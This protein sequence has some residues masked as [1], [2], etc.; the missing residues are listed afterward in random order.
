MA[1]FEFKDSNYCAFWQD[2]EVLGTYVDMT[3][4]LRTNFNF[5]ES[6]FKIDPSLTPSDSK[7]LAAFT[8]Q[9]LVREPAPMMDMV[10]PLG[11]G[12]ALDKPGLSAYTASIPHFRA[13]SYHENSQERAYMA[14]QFEQFGKDAELIK[15]WTFTIQGMLDSANQT[16]SNMS[17]QLLSTGEIDYKYGR[18]IK[19]HLYNANIPA[20][21]IVKAGHESSSK[22]W[23]DKTAPLLDQMAGI[24]EDYRTRL[25]LENVPL[26]WQI[27]YDM[28]HKNF[29]TNNQVRQFVKDYRINN[30]LA[31]TDGFVITEDIFRQ[32]LALYPQISPIEIIVEKQKDYSGN[33]NGWKDGVAVLRPAGMAGLI[34]HTD[35]LEEFLSKNFGG[36][37]VTKVFTSLNPLMTL[38]NA[39]LNN[40]EYKEWHT[41]LIMAAVPALDEV[42]YH[43]I[44]NT[45]QAGTGKGSL[46]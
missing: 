31:T 12:K 13:P 44:V 42:P 5:W 15:Q 33:V 46:D 38:I 1:K 30:Q 25:G 29:L 21:N 28:F 24:E 40:G 37:A 18:A 3:P 23:T 39:T 10:A 2:G 14:K 35:H 32:V 16:L 9:S 20:E 7:G 6:Q 26:K 41:D 19:N 17:A 43:L 34:K 45:K 11:R 22:V 8:M 27:P 36:D 4:Y